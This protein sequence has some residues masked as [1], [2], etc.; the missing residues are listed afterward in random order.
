MCKKSQENVDETERGSRALSTL[1]PQGADLLFC[2][3]APILSGSIFFVSQIHHPLCH[4]FNFLVFS[5]HWAH[6]NSFLYTT[7]IILSCIHY[8]SCSFSN[9]ARP[10][11]VFLWFSTH[12]FVLL[13]HLNLL[14]YHLVSQLQL[15]WICIQQVNILEFLG[16]CFSPGCFLRLLC[17]RFFGVVDHLFI[18]SLLFYLMFEVIHRTN[19]WFPFIL[20][21]F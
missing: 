13:F 15:C 9:V 5:V 8:I 6:L 17:V 2:W 14:L 11:I 7:D 10:K 1:A 4:C 21:I 16:L 20:F 3:N 12:F 18:P 19:R